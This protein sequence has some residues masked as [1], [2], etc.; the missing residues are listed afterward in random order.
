MPLT[1][2]PFLEP[3]V[4]ERRQAR[5]DHQARVAARDALR[6]DPDERV[7]AAPEDVL[8]VR[9]RD[10]AVAPEQAEDLVARWPGAAVARAAPR[11]S[12]QNA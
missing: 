1:N 3:E 12:P 5:G 4:L 6:V 10:L 9:Q 7:G 11:P 2:V 8:A